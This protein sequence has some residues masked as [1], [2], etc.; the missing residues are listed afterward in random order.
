MSY[1]LC[2]MSHMYVTG[3]G[4]TFLWVFFYTKMILCFIFCAILSASMLLC[5]NFCII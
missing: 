3:E 1:S 4:A 2:E 5:Y